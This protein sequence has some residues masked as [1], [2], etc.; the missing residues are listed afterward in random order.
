MSG[1]HSLNV[2]CV[3]EVTEKFSINCGK[4]FVPVLGGKLKDNFACTGT[5]WYSSN[6]QILLGNFAKLVQWTFVSLLLYT[7]QGEKM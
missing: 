7:N 2:G 5:F 6:G 1:P 3:V 4:R